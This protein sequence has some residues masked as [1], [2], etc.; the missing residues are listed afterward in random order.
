MQ[1][2]FNH[3]TSKVKWSQRSHLTDSDIAEIRERCTKDYYIIA[4]RKRNYLSTFF[5]GLANFFLTG[6]WGFYSHVLMNLEDKVEG[7]E[8]FRFIEATGTGTHYSTLMD[9]FGTVDAVALIKPKSMTVAEWTAALDSVKKYLGIPYDNLFDL[10]NTLEINCVE[11]V[12]LALSTL[13]DYDTRFAQF[14]EFIKEKA[15]KLTPEMFLMC[16][17]FHVVWEVKR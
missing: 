10:R 3:F 17:D 13:P 16:D 15:D 1:I 4:T 12:R 5:I 9:V 11:L 8:D 7:D 6:K 2:A 14:E